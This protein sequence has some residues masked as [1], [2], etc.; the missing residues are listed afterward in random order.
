MDSNKE[1]IKHLENSGILKNPKLKK[2]IEKNPR[3]FFVRAE[4]KRFAYRDAPLPIGYGQT[5]SQPTTVLFMLELL[6]MESGQKVLEIGTGS[7]WQTAI[8][9]LIVG[10]EGKVFSF[11]IVNQLSEFAK[12]NLSNFDYSNTILYT[13][14]FEKKISEI[15]PFDRVV[16]GAAFSEIPQTLKTALKIKG[17]LVAPTQQDDIRVITRTGVNKFK[18]DIYPG[19]VF[20]PVTH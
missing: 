12:K 19:F 8:V 18:E 15:K 5:I 4:D 2:A 20:V 16:S 6:E 11:E 9:S 17:K 14:D 1:L 10:S 3:E 13:C 7:G